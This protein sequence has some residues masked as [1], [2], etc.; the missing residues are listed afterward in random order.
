MSDDDIS[1]V[2]ISADELL[3][4]SFGLA[5][6]IWDDGFKPNFLVGL[7]RGGSP[8]G[9]VIH[10]FFEYKGVELYHTAIKTQ[11]YRGIMSSGPVAIKG[12]GHVI[13]IINSE[14]N[15]L[16]VDD[17]FDSGHTIKAVL[18]TIRRN[19]RKN[20]PHIRIATVYYKPEKNM[21]DIVPD[22]YMVEN[23]NWLVFPHELKGLTKEEILKKRPLLSRYLFD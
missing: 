3:E 17:V 9:I 7:W 2:Y 5:K 1:K 18:T 11:S 10:E 19:A 13:E 14:D 23:N 8:P 12:L 4:K 15:M 16:I 21:T 20:T 6:K 22:Y